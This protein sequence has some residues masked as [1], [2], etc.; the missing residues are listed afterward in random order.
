[1]TDLITGLTDE[2]IETE[3]GMPTVVATADD[4]DGGDEP[5]T[6]TDTDGTDGADADGT[7]GEDAD[8]TDGADVD[9]ADTADADGAD[10]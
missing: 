6:D 7:D 2:E 4:A 10:A 8:G 9:G 5:A 1:M 3:G